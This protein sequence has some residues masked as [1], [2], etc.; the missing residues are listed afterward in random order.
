MCSEQVR[1]DGLIVL[2]ASGESECVATHL[3]QPITI[4]AA[5]NENSVSVRNQ[6]GSVPGESNP[7]SASRGTAIPT[8]Y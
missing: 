6:R 5:N 2:R 7:V 1:L 3:P 8:D 4:L